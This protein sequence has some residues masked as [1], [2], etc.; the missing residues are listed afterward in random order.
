MTR[1]L[2][3]LACLTCLAVASPSFAGGGAPEFFYVSAKSGLVLRATASP[4][5]AQLVLIP[6]GN[7]LVPQAWGA[8]AV[9]GGVKGKWCQVEVRDQ[10]G[11]MTT[12]WVFGGFLSAAILPGFHQV[13]TG[14]I[15]GAEMGDY[16]H[17]NVTS[18]A[19]AKISVFVLS[20]FK[21][22]AGFDAAVAMGGADLAGKKVRLVWAKRK[23]WLDSAGGWTAVEEL[24]EI[25]YLP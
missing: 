6:Y 24:D 13:V 16:A 23:A 22:P 20:M 2:A 17:L 19:G 4:T 7:K 9:I 10:D 8:Q 12:G 15:T 1:A 11:K 25:S 5:A 21:K 14:T 18:S 3:L